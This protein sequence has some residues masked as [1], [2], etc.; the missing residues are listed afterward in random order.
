MELSRIEWSG[1][2]GRGEFQGEAVPSW[3]KFAKRTI[4]SRPVA[5][6]ASRILQDRSLTQEKG[7]W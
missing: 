2:A 6:Y 3:K 1:F 5:Q 4:I 7:T